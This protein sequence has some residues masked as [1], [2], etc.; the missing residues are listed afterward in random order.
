MAG[1]GPLPNPQKRRRNAP[2]IPTT[3]LPA[4]GRT[5]T[6]P[7][8]PKSH[9]LGKAGTAWWKWAWHTPQAAAWDPGALYTIAHRA[10]L[11][12]SLAL[13]AEIVPMR[14]AEFLEVDPDERL[15]VVEDVLRATRALAGGRLSVMKEIRELDD[16]LGLTP[17][18]LAQLRW[19]I[20]EDTP[21][22][23]ADTP[24]PSASRYGHLRSVHGA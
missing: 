9:P 14:L 19:R 8:P 11:E 18:G 2:T 4:G 20:V 16:R 1:K 21:T 10:Q 23:D 12:D 22:R 13:L 15:D 5:G 3:N 24:A 7:R 17:K 6:A